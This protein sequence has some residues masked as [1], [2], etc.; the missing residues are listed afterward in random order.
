MSGPVLR[1][2][3]AFV[4]LIPLTAVARTEAQE[5]LSTPD[6]ASV[7]PIERALAAYDRGDF[8]DARRWFEVAHAASPSAR[9]LRGLGITAFALGDF[10]TARIELAASLTHPVRPLSEELRASVEALLAD[11][12]AHLGR[13]V[14]SE[15]T[16]AEGS[17]TPT[18]PDEARGAVETTQPTTV[19]D[20]AADPED[21]SPTASPTPRHPRMRR[22]GRSLLIGESV[23]SA[24][25]ATVYGIA[26]RRFARVQ[27]RCADG[28][29]T[30]AIDRLYA[31]ENIDGLRWAGAGSLIAGLALGVG[32]ATS[33][34]LARRGER[35]PVVVAISPSR[36]VIS[37]SF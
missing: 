12:T 18:V 9:T 13:E 30:D 14:D 7:D 1:F 35:A 33:L 17:A 26:Y 37:G 31:A 6:E 29:S 15:A 32:G 21:D 25:A 10:E 23:V 36:L 3:V 20:E 19:P 11:T 8:V 24:T 4:V 16:V 34:G 22:V 28:C 5:S 2:A 27:D